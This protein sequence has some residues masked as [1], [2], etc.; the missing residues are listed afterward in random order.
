MYGRTGILTGTCSTRDPEA[1]GVAKVQV[2]RVGESLIVTHGPFGVHTN[3]LA[4]LVGE[5]TPVTASRQPSSW[6][7][8]TP[9]SPTNPATLSSHGAPHP[10]KPPTLPLTPRAP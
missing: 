9:S 1:Y 3:E 5:T 10:K 6:P 8:I 2:A 4:P 7:A